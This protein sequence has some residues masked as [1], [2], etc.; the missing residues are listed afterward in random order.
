MIF[1]TF[2][3]TGS[4]ALSVGSYYS[5]IFNV[6]LFFPFL[7]QYVHQFWFHSDCYFKLQIAPNRGIYNNPVHYRNQVTKLR[8]SMVA[9]RDETDSAE[10]R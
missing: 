7:E 2:T 4:I 10:Y 9:I 5:Y 3:P 6:L 8:Y 1:T